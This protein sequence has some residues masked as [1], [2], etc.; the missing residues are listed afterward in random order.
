VPP[1]RPLHSIV[2]LKKNIMSDHSVVVGEEHDS[3]LQFRSIIT[4]LKVVATVSF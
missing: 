2:M 1:I 3:A 4:I